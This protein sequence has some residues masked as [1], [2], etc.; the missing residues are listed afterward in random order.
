MV[1]DG[2]SSSAEVGCGSATVL[3]EHFSE[4][5]ETSP[6][7]Y[8]RAFST[9]P[10]ASPVTKRPLLDRA[11]LAIA[12]AWTLDAFGEEMVYRGYL[13]NR[14]ADLMN[15]TRWAWIVSLFV[16]HVGFGLACPS[17]SSNFSQPRS[18]YSGFGQWS[19]V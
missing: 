13:M 9:G 15:R 18:G 3:R 11:V 2:E 7:V 10:N 5:A 6:S 8:L 12:G 17:S 1:Q 16:V 4:I 19:R 14:I